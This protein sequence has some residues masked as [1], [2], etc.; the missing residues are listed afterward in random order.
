MNFASIADVYGPDSG[1]I[2]SIFFRTGEGA[3]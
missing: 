2:S 1:A 3:R